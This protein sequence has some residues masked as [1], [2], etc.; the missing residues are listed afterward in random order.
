MTFGERLRQARLEREMTQQELAE[1]SGIAY[2]SI[3][4]YEQGRHEPGLF[5]ATCLAIALGVSL[6]WL[7]G[8]EEK[9]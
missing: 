9:R 3:K 8:I 7:A 4:K 2:N 6:D 5:C 1:V